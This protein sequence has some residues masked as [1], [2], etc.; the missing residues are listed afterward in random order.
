MGHRLLCP[1]ISPA[2]TAEGCLGGVVMTL[3][4]AVLAGTVLP[5]LS[6]G[7]RIILGAVVAAGATA[8]DL[9]FSCIKRRLGIKDFAS[10]L[11]GHG[12]LLDRFDSLVVA[13][14]LGTWVLRWILCR[15]GT[16]R[17]QAGVLA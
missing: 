4:V 9:V 3:L 10:T 7:R 11:P 1:A 16:A 13:A 17:A 8:G 12:G 6:A 2:K 14:P 5:G 15:W